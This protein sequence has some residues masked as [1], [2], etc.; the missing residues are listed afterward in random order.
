MMSIDSHRTRVPLERGQISRL[1]G[2]RDARLSSGCGTLW[3]TIDHDPRDI[4]LEPGESFE[5]RSDEQVV[6][7][8]LGGPAVLELRSAAIADTAGWMR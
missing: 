6:I 7:C 5:L 1:S 2:A 4:I 3:V 8:A